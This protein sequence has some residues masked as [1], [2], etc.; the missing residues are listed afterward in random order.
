MYN[1]VD[2]VICNL[3]SDS[4]KIRTMSK[5]KITRKKKKKKK[6]RNNK[7]VDKIVV[8]EL[9]VVWLIRYVLLS[10]LRFA[11]DKKFL[12]EFYIAEYYLEILRK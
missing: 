7:K 2:S 6:K 3:Y 4:L 12:Q 1:Y 5:I 11:K 9:Q 10:Y 8:R